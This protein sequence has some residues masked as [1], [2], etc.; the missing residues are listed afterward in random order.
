MDE[1]DLVRMEIKTAKNV[2]FH[3]KRLVKFFVAVAH[4]AY[5]R[6]A[7]MGKMDAYL[8]R[9]AGADGHLKG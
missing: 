8:V 2:S 1:T 5:D 6:T 3:E 4:V 9:P 7:D